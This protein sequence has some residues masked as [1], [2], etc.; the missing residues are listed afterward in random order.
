MKET[1]A[2]HWASIWGNAV[3]IGENRPESYGHR[4]VLPRHGLFRSRYRRLHLPLGR[5][6][7]RDVGSIGGDA[8]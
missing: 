5:G 1:T 8:R 4:G 2:M 3:S 6:S 7:P